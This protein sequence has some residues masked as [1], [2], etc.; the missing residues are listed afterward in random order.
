MIYRFDQGKDAALQ[1]KRNISLENILKA[2]EDGKLIDEIDHPNRSKYPNQKYL[3]VSV[4]HYA[5]VVPSVKAG[6]TTFMKTIYPS[7]KYTKIYKGR[8]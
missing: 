4:H 3:I 7:R 6:E 1:V 8:L 2:I 5:Y